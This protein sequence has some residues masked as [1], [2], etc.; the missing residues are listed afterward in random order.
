MTKFGK[1]LAIVGGV[2]LAGSC[3]AYLTGGHSSAPDMDKDGT[4]YKIDASAAGTYVTEGSQR[5][6]GRPCNWTRTRTPTIHI[7]D[8]IAGGQV[9]VGERGAVT[10]NAGEYFVTY[11]CKPWRKQ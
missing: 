7:S 2:A 9:A 1:V 4:Y 10:V 3:V 8:M 5:T 11:G 6:N